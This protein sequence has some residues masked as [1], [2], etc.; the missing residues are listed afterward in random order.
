MQSCVRDGFFVLL[1]FFVYRRCMICDCNDCYDN[2]CDDC[3]DCQGQGWG[4]G[5]LGDMND[6]YGYYDYGSMFMDFVSGMQQG[7][8]CYG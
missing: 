3:F 8:Q 4:V 6:C 5:C 1:F 7:G 2:S